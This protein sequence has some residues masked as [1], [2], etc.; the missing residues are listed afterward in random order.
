MIS[1]SK[2][3]KEKSSFVTEDD[4][5]YLH[6]LVE[7]KDEGP[8]WIQMM[9]RSTPNMS[10]QAWRRDPAVNFSSPNNSVFRL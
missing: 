10:Y 1:S 7:E 2:L 8:A 6:Q 9:D 4:L 5:K 3:D